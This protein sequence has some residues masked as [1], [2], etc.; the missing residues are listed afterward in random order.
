[1]EVVAQDAV[2]VV[3]AEDPVFELG[4]TKRSASASGCGSSG[5]SPGTSTS[6]APRCFER[7]GDFGEIDFGGAEFAGG[8]ID[9]REAGARR[10]R[11]HTAAR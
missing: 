7:A 9:V 2:G 3:G 6:R 8:D 4:A 1:M 5:S 11:A 10:R